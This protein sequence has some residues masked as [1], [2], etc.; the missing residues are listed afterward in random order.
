MNKSWRQRFAA[1]KRDALAGFFIFAVTLATFLVSRVHQVG[2][3]HF[4]MLLSE[5]LLEHRSF[6]L[7]NYNLSNVELSGGGGYV[8]LDKLYQLETVGG[9]VY[10]LFPP[11]SSILSLPFVALMKIFGV[12]PVNPDGS[13]NRY[14]EVKIQVALAALLMAAL[15]SVFFFTARLVLP[16]GWS[17]LVALG[18]AWGTQVW[19]T[20]S[21]AL[22]SDT[23]G[24]FLLGVV[25]WML[26][27]TASGKHRLRPILLASLLAWM[28]F[29]RPT[30]SIPIL[31]ITVYVLVFHRRS[32][33][34]YAV[35][36]ILWL[37][38][39]VAY[40]WYHFGQVLPN[41]YQANRLTFDHFGEALAGNLISPARGLLVYVPVLLFIFYLLA[42][43][44]KHLTYQRLVLLGLVVITSHWIATSG[45][46]HW[47]GGHGYGPRLMTGVVPWLVLLG[48]LGLQARLNWREEQAAR[49]RRTWRIESALGGTLLLMSMVI[50]GLG[51]TSHANWLWNMRPVDVDQQPSRIWDWRHP[52]FLAKWQS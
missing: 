21:R 31:A 32:F 15:A 52:Q 43:Y 26:L 44:R 2:D 50:N 5:S 10:Y 9:R 45:F 23:W 20:A 8:K 46:I 38:A 24:I 42:R 34:W 30:N 27:A 14:N 48:I 12:T 28:Y 40:S 16:A 41:Y 29:V 4:T 1:H 19:S 18:G 3:S 17:A 47:Y 7:D 22:W 35:T 13:Y 49:K 37:A 33:V 25:L 51:A 11:G 36:G 39:F 6:A